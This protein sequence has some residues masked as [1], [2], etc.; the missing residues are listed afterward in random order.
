MQALIVQGGCGAISAEE[1][2]LRRAACERAADAGWKALEAGRGAL[3]AVEGDALESEDA[4]GDLVGDLVVLAGGEDQGVDF[5][6]REVAEDLVRLHRCR[7]G[8]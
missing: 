6:G 4:P 3:E 8:G 7:D 2:V 5:G 1:E